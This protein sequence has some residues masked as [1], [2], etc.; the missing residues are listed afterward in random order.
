MGWDQRGKKRYYYRTQRQNGRPVRTYFGIGETAEL[1]ATADALV[2]V[3]REMDARKWQ[4]QQENLASAEALLKE[5]FEG[6]DLLVR[7]ALI[8]A[9]YHQHDRGVWRLKRAQQSRE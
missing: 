9:G 3:Q 1:A 2:R 8:V 4:Q 6:S 7:A 5:I